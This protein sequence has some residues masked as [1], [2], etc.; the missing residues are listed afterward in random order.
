MDS[1]FSGFLEN[2]YEVCEWTKWVVR[3]LVIVADLCQN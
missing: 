2:N 3:V 1:P